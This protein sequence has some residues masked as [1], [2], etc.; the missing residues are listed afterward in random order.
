MTA[1]VLGGEGGQ[2]HPLANATVRSGAVGGATDDSGVVRLALPPGPQL[3]VAARLGFAPESLSAVV[4]V[5]VDTAMTF[6]LREAVA[7][8]A[9]VIVTAARGERRIEDEPTRVEVLAGEDVAEKTQMRPANPTTLLSEI[10]GVRVQP[11]AP[12]LGGAGVRLQGLRGRYTLL[13]VDGLPLYGAASEGLGFLQVPPLDLAQ[14]EVIKGAA[15]ALYGPAALGGVVNLVSRRPPNDGG[16]ENE[17]LVNQS[18]QGGSDGL[19]WSAAR[20]SERWGYTF[21]GGGHRQLRR[22][23][24]GDGWAE[25]PGFNRG[26]LRPRLFWRGR[27]GNSAM[28]TAGATDE[29]RVGGSDDGPS[30]I[31]AFRVAARTRRA[32][33]GT[34]VRVGAGAAL[35]TIRASVNRQWQGRQFGDSSESDQRGTAFA[36]ASWARTIGRHELLIGAAVQRDALAGAT[37][38]DATYRFMTHS[39]F[40]EDTWAAGQRFSL[41]MGARLDEHSRYGTFVS[42]RASVLAKLTGSWSARLSAAGGIFAPTPLVEEADASGLSRIRGLGQLSAERLRYTSLDINGALG[43]LEVNGTVFRS[44]LR[45]A[46][47]IGEPV[48]TPEV[49]MLANAPMPTRTSGAELFAVYNREPLVVTALYSY[50]G[51]AEWSAEEARRVAAPLVPRH[52]AGV[53]VAF[54][55]DESGTRI[56]LELFYTGRQALADDPYRAVGVPYTTLGILASQQLG[57]F[58]VFVNGENLTD[59]RQS[60]FEPLLRPARR[61]T[62]AW[63]TDQWA[64]LEG[65]VINAGVRVRL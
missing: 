34:I 65:R 32:D 40:A 47:V 9:P 16:G 51:S 27:S 59:V 31:G 6:H 39:V 24:D 61:A 1:T 46:V 7:Q 63:T 55:E 33:A 53:D 60:R 22:D 18:S 49:L 21:I 5:G 43:P 26:E 14:A 50:T 48:A 29:D 13:L 42:P 25:I 12:A 57:A 20:L 45:S 10:P 15:T 56:G 35:V 62:G 11:T 23:P 28:F 38:P 8:I 19:L 54:E 64:P 3:F 37:L 4:K 44:S 30:G 2:L 52:A 41:A 17:L 58:D 36:E